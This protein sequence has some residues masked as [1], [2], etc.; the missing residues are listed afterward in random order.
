MRLG[1]GLSRYSGV[2]L[3][4]EPPETDWYQST[5]TQ[6]EYRESGASEWKSAVGVAR[7]LVW[8]TRAVHAVEITGLEPDTDY[9]VRLAGDAIVV[10]LRW[11]HDPTTTMV[12]HW[13]T[14]GPLPDG[15]YG[16][17]SSEA[18]VYK[19]R[20]MP[21]TLPESGVRIIHLTD[22]HSGREQVRR[23]IAQAAARDPRFMFHTG[24]WVNSDRPED[25]ALWFEWWDTYFE[26]ARDSEGRLIPII[27]NTGNHEQYNQNVGKLASSD[28]GVRPDFDAN[29]PPR[30]Q[31]NV[32]GYPDIVL[33]SIMFHNPNYDVDGHDRSIVLDFGN[34][35]SLWQLDANTE[36]KD[37]NSQFLDETLPGRASVPHKILGLH[38][39]PYPAGRRYEAYH[40]YV[41]DTWVPKLE[42]YGVDT[43]SGHEHVWAVSPR[44]KGGQP[45][46]D[47]IYHLGQGTSGATEREGQNK[48]A[49]NKWWIADNRVIEIG[50]FDWEKDPESPYYRPPHPDDNDTFPEGNVWHTWEIE[51]VSMTER[52]YRTLWYDGTV[53]DDIVRLVA[54]L[55]A[56]D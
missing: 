31:Q 46:P 10:Y 45:D 24:D 2:A 51:I 8:S 26:E 11:I 40:E 21:A 48:N 19:F 43:F 30:G 52:R 38:Y 55:A 3:D 13:H 12:V 36:T 20:T 44:I 42:Q 14:D 50:Y 25:V 22:T 32:P 15:G 4:I 16:S 29:I 6:L 9:E 34:W 54:Q 37:G 7:N 17:P 23:L 49:D 18:D 39:S 53:G 1:L 35:L 47:G 33:Y 56:R 28:L 5:P 27:P 41:R